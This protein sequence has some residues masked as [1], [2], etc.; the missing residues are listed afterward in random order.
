[1]PGTRTRVA[2]AIGFVA[3][4]A[5]FALF[6]EHELGK[7]EAL[8]RS[9]SSWPTTTATVTESSVRLSGTGRRKGRRYAPVIQYEYRVEGRGSFSS[10]RYRIVPTRS[11]E[12]A[13]IQ[14]IVDR[15]PAG[16]KVPVS[17]DPG[18][19]H[20]SVL[21]PGWTDADDGAKSRRRMFLAGGAVLAAL[22]GVGI[23]LNPQKR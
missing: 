21:A 8:Q 23:V 7:E 5:L 15:F 6:L 10:S 22:M 19:P 11:S 16:A 20:Q 17:Y 4:I 2:L 14:A 9:T 18:A 1:M 12:S 13:E 3:F